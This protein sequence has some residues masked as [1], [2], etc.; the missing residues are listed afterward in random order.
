[1][2]QRAGTPAVA[3]FDFRQQRRHRVVGREQSVVF[4]HGEQRGRHRLG[5]RADVPAI[6]NGHRDAGTPPALATGGRTDKPSIG[7]DG[8]NH[9][10]EPGVVLQPGDV[11]L[12]PIR[13]PS[14][15]HRR[16]RSPHSA[17]RAGCA[18]R[19][20]S[21]VQGSASGPPILRPP[22]P[23]ACRSSSVSLAAPRTPRQL[24]I[25]AVRLVG[26]T[27]GRRLS[28]RAP[29][30]DAAT[31]AR[32]W[33]L[34]RTGWGQPHRPPPPSRSGTAGTGTRRRV[35]RTNCAGLGSSPPPP[36]SS[37]RAT[38]RGPPATGSRRGPQGGGRARRSRK[39]RSATLAAAAASSEAG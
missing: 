30:Q 20:W 6:V 22:R 8:G 17:R 21:S 2:V 27:A 25:V 33:P 5:D 12:E 23:A 16:H 7:H 15:P 32:R 3:R 39:T 18:R 38:R 14:R 10:G 35:R 9:P 31:A 13:P 11:G 19:R 34:P 28:E 36:C 37:A 26:S 24:V 29:V 4:Q 1:M